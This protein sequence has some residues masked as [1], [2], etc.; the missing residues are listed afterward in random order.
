[1]A[2]EI[3]RVQVGDEIQ[4]SI[5]SSRVI[6]RRCLVT[7]VRERAEP[8]GQVAIGRFLTEAGDWSI[9]ERVLMRPWRTREGER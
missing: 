4:A 1:M 7:E 9:P 3:A 8:I 5:R 6:R 2:D